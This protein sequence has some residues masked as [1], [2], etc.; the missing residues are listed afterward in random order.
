M[1]AKS[2]TLRM[3]AG[4]E[5]ISKGEIRFDGV[6]VNDMGPSERNIALAFESYA[7]YYRMTVFENIAFPLRAKGLKG[8]QVD[9]QVNEIA[10]VLNLTTLLQEKT[11]RTG[12]RPSAKD[13]SCKG[14]YK[15]TKCNAS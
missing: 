1:A 15:E 7:L 6:V 12:W 2:S 4:L 3:L 10:K 8:K 5:E 13:L 11:C 9:E 14:P